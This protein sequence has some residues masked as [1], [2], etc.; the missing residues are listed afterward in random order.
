MSWLAEWIEPLIHREHW[1]NEH[2]LE[3]LLQQEHPPHML[4]LAGARDERVPAWHTEGLWEKLK[5]WAPKIGDSVSNVVHL[6]HRFTDGSHTC[7]TQPEYHQRIKHFMDRI[8]PEEVN[9][10]SQSA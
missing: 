8:F 5:A 3:R 10:H 1:N 4:L 7:H 6:L 2:Q 9:D